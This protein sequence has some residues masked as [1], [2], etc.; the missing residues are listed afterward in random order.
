MLAWH[1][2]LFLDPS[3][4][5]E[6]KLCVA[7]KRKLQVRVTFLVMSTGDCVHSTVDIPVEQIPVVQALSYNVCSIK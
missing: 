1:N 3:P 4:P 6:L 7:V 5:L 2:L